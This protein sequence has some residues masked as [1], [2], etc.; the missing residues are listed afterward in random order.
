MNVSPSFDLPCQQSDCR[1]YGNQIAGQGSFPEVDAR[2]QV[3]MTRSSCI[4]KVQKAV[5][6]NG[7][8]VEDMK[9]C[10]T[11]ILRSWREYDLAVMII[12]YGKK[13]LDITPESK[14]LLDCGNEQEE[15]PEEKSLERLKLPLSLKGL[16]RFFGEQETLTGQLSGS[17]REN[18]VVSLNV[19]SELSGGEDP[20]F[21]YPV[22]L[23]WSVKGAVKEDA[24]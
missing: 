8:A 6:G 5:L 7:S 1:I 18:M 4:N 23:N 13:M 2:A 24:K 21:L 10:N 20:I 3:L 12:N 11:M 22:V 15:M 14:S 17:D 19:S 16:G 9:P